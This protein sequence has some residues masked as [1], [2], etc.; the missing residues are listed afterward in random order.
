[1]ELLRQIW[2][3]SVGSKVIAA[4]II[5]LAGSIGAWVKTK[6]SEL[7]AMKLTMARH[8]SD[9]FNGYPGGR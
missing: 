9:M 5:F 7:W 6:W 3:D 1:M 8:V 2:H 4:S